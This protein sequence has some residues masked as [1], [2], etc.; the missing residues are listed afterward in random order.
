M[1]DPTIIK[2]AKG[3]DGNNII[4]VLQTNIVVNIQQI[5]FSLSTNYFRGA[6]MHSLKL[7]F[8]ILLELI[9][10]RIR[11]LGFMGHMG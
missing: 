9:S 11:C 8:T 2:R 5:A 3:T 4:C 1:Y 10:S 7:H 6:S